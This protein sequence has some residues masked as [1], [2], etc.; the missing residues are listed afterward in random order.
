MARSICIVGGGASDVAIA[1]AFA[2][3]KRLGLRSE[4]L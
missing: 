1:W 3:A 4:T 2:K